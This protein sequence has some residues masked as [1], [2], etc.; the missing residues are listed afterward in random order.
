MSRG[1]G[2]VYKRQALLSVM[3][4][5]GCE[6]D[7][8]MRQDPLPVVPHP[9]LLVPDAGAL[10]VDAPLRLV[11]DAGAT[12]PRIVPFATT[13][14]GE[15][16]PLRITVANAP[17]HLGP[18]GYRLEVLADGITARAKAPAGLH[19]AL[20]TLRQLLPPEAEQGP[21]TEGAP[22]SISLATIEDEPRFPWRGM[23]LD[24]CR[25]FFTVEEVKQ[26][27]DLL[28]LFKFNTFHWHLTEDQGWRIAIQA[29]PKLTEVGSRRAESPLPGDRTKGDGTPYGGHYTQD[30]IREVVAYARDRYI[31]VVPEI[32]MPGHA[33]AAIAAYPELGNTDEPL[34]VR[35]RWGVSKHV[36]NVEEETFAFLEQV[37]DEVLALFPSTFVHIGGDECPKDEWKASAKAQA[38]MKA[39]GLENEHE[40]QSWFIR[41]IEG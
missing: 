40:L 26:F 5:T 18:E 38:R 34:E 7:D 39:E 30:D 24:V 11:R 16:V 6:K 27:L 32:E 23:H 22:W 2:D 13:G 14:S 10:H 8:V 9:V 33:Q 4:L 15:G 37:L 29:Y 31:T 17:A 35:T 1:L 28:A 3:L 36:Y 20:Q 19:Y 25:H 41:R 21:P 12:E